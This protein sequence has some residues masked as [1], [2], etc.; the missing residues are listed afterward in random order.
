MCKS[1]KRFHSNKLINKTSDM[2]IEISQYTR[3]DNEYLRASKLPKIRLVN[4]FN[5]ELGYDV[6]DKVPNEKDLWVVYDVSS[7]V[8]IWNPTTNDWILARLVEPWD[9]A[10]TQENAL[11]VL[12]S[13]SPK[14]SRKL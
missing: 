10:M 5:E 13:I 1:Y 7:P 9:C 11:K 12:E 4:R 3:E 8:Y 14:Y 2:I 6:Q